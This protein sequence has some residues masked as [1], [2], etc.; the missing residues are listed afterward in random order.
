MVYFK[1]LNQY[2]GDKIGKYF[3]G[4]LK[5]WVTSSVSTG[6]VISFTHTEETIAAKELAEIINS[7][8]PKPRPILTLALDEPDFLP[9]A[10]LVRGLRCGAAV[11][12]LV[13]DY[14]N[15]GG[16]ENLI[17]IIKLNEYSKKEF[18]E[19]ISVKPEDSFFWAAPEPL[20]EALSNETF[21][22][23][24]TK[25][26][27][28]LMPLGVGTGFLVGRNYLL[29]N[30]HVLDHESIVK[31][32]TAEFRYEQD[33]L[34]RDVTPVPY[35]LDSHFFYTNKQLDY[36]LVKLNR[37]SEVEREENQLTFHEAGDNFGWLPMFEDPTVIAP[38]FSKKDKDAESIINAL[39]ENIQK[40]LGLYDLPGDIVSIIQHPKGRRKEIVLFNNR[41]QKIYK[42]FLEYEADAD[43]GSSGSPV[44]NR[45]WQLVGLHH[46]AL[47]E[48]TEDK[49]VGH[50]G[51]R[52]SKIV[53]DLKNVND[54]EEVNDK[55]EELKIFLDS[56]V[57]MKD[58]KV[59]KKGSRG[60][61]FISAGRV[62]G[63][64]VDEIK[65]ANLMK[66]LGKQIESELQ[67]L[68]SS[69]GFQ[70]LLVPDAH[71]YSLQAV[72]DWI[73]DQDYRAG[74]MAIEILTDS[75]RDQPD[76]RGAC[77][78]YI[79]SK[80]ERKIHAELLL[81]SLLSK[82][83]DLPSRGAKPDRDT[84]TRKLSFCRGIRM[85]SLVM[86]VGYLTNQEDQEII[87]T[88]SED[89]ALGI[90][91]G[92]IAWGNSLSPIVNLDM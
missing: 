80:V 58:G 42:S 52:T 75:L 59:P 39:E 37:L 90:T 13:R 84:V 77:I 87:T 71:T 61:I 88:R 29:T 22:E 33:Y 74:D 11:C 64:S 86:Y 66:L 45:Q 89:M 63:G 21:K 9:I 67:K 34:G 20:S 6:Q 32:F 25:K 16:I 38:P 47:V 57:V 79:E 49:V 28:E 17:E 68:Q 62:R 18:A 70:V 43:L 26:L 2:F 55:K 5:E 12:R 65:E 10:S 56:F 83:P 40:R 19:L 36:T 31:E 54:K 91:Q 7:R 81:Q 1:I 69:H 78:F 48:K 41:V 30:N 73:N 53:E 8:T 3:D 51:I 50:L 60:R 85:P 72:I 76:V 92:L 4:R 46:A 15:L 23:E 24:L 35:K 27:R 44:L 14:S 82:V